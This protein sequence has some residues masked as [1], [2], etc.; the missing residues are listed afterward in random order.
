MPALK[1]I[2]H[3]MFAQNYCICGNASEAWRQAT[4]KTKD[5]D[6][7]AAEFMV[8]RGMKE[9]IDEIK[10]ITANRSERKKEEL[11]KFIWDV[12]DG[13]IEADPQQLRAA[14]LLGRMHG[15]NEPEK[16][17]VTGEVKITITKQ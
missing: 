9:R 15:W 11:V 13:H 10:E 14:E 12:V 4:G 2:K 3:E 16:S 6:T 1:N 8:V 5:A 7:H 17:D